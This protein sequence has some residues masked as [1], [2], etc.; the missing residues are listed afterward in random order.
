MDKLEG[1]LTMLLKDTTDWLKFAE[2]KNLALITFN[3]AWLSYFIKSI[4]DVNNMESNKIYVIASIFCIISLLICFIAFIPKLIDFKLIKKVAKMLI[5]KQSPNDNMLFYKH[6]C[7][8][9]PS[10]Y[11]EKFQRKFP[12][13]E[14]FDKYNSN[15][16]RY[17]KELVR[18][19][20]ALAHIAFKK[21]LLFNLAIIITIIPFVIFLVEVIK[22]IN[23][24]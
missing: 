9:E 3:S 11:Y 6:I 21:Y 14:V 24:A 2:A 23:G 18:Q 19:I 16:N 8:Y 7:K 22:K 10:E 17:V 5:G 4:F 1:K 20:S 15:Q 13:G 12:D